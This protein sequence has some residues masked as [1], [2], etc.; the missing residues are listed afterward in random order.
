MFFVR[1]VVVGGVFVYR[2]VYVVCFNIGAWSRLLDMTSIK[3][4]YIMEGECGWGVAT[5]APASRGVLIY[6]TETRA[7]CYAGG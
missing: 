5:E 7:R 4:L 1:L 2:R 3:R 6:A